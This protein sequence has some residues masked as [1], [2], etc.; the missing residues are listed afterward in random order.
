MRDVSAEIIASITTAAGTLVLAVATFA[1]TR[2]A[3]RASRVAERSLLAG[4]RPVLMHARLNDPDQKIGFGDSHWVHVEGSG[5]AFEA[6]DGVIYLVVALRNVG[7]GLAVLQGWDPTPNL[8]FGRS[9][10]GPIEKFRLQ[11]RDIYVAAGDVGFW[12]GAFRDQT[13]PL[14]EPFLAAARDRSPVTIDVLYTD[15]HGGQRSV[16]SFSIQP[17]RESRWIAMVGRH[18]MIDGVSPR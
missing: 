15:M 17:G 12:Q 11:T 10:H 14:F 16:T 2:S 1:S 6:V 5:A 3:N 7:S 4:L 8:V 18:W 13:D 9:T